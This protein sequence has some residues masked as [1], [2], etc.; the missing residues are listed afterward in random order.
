MRLPDRMKNIWDAIK[1]G[2]APSAGPSTAPYFGF[3]DAYH[4]RR[5]PRPPELLSSY[6]NIAYSC[7]QLNATAV[8]SGKLRLFHRGTRTDKPTNVPSK[9]VEGDEL[10]YLMKNSNSIPILSNDEVIREISQH[11]ILTMLDRPNDF[12][13]RFNL[14]EWTVL[15][16][17]IL[18]DAYWSFEWY[19]VDGSKVP[20]KIW[21]LQAHLM[22][23]IP[24]LDHNK[25]LLHYEYAAAVGKQIYLPD[26]L[27]HFKYTGLADPY[28]Y[29]N[30]PLRACFE[31]ATVSDKLLAYEEALLDNRAR[32][33]MLITPRD[34]IGKDEARRLER[35]FQQQFR[36]GGS[37]GIV[38]AESGFDY[39]SMNFAPADLASLE[40]RK[41]AKEE[42]A[43]AFGVPPSM[44][45]AKDINR[46]TAEAG[47]Y[48]HAKCAVMPRCRRMEEFLNMKLCPLYDPNIFLSFDNPV[49]EDEANRRETRRINIEKGV[50]TINEERKRD[51]LPPIPGGDDAYLPGNYYPIK[52]LQLIAESIVTR[53][54]SSSVTIPGEEAVPDVKPEPI[55]ASP[56]LNDNQDGD[57]VPDETDDMPDSK[58]FRRSR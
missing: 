56:A 48:Q 49:P 58:R 42:I 39:K 16:M 34:V 7:A 22:T 46:A 5:P 43:N 35:K 41:I 1:S 33:D 40:V 14:I 6:K 10:Q 13:G 2:G 8:A 38:V 37:G 54:S 55:P 18:G 53:N 45:T 11:P 51:G 36:G 20:Y 12:H 21:P 24:D 28:L 3:L 29:G 9:I 52:M 17:D 50:H 31:Q 32:P 19:D 57:E 26:E 15:S 25:I 44:L 23:P 27:I 47:H 4:S 30:A